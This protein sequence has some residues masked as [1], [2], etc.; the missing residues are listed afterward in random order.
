M[1]ELTLQRP[2]LGNVDEG[3]HRADNFPTAVDRMGPVFGGKAGAVTAPENF[4]FDV[5]AFYAPKGLVNVAVFHGVMRP[6]LP[7]VVDEGVHVLSQQVGRLLITYQPETGWIAECAIALHVDAVD[8]FGDGIQQ[9]S[10]LFF[11]SLALRD[12]AKGPDSS[13]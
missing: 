1:A 10:H 13:V 7:S 2:A 12:V 3:H 6:I 9:F 5:S 11:P 8:C 4:V